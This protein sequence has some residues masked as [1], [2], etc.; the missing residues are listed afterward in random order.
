MVQLV[1]QINDP[2]DEKL[3]IRPCATASLFEYCELGTLKGLIEKRRDIGK[4]FTAYEVLMMAIQLAEGLCALKKAGLVHRDLAPRNIFVARNDKDE[5]VCKI[6]DIGLVVQL[7]PERVGVLSANVF[8]AH[9]LLSALDTV[10]QFL[11][12]FRASL[13][14]P[15]SYFGRDQCR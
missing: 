2:G 15:I 4:P 11:S 3:G 12:K 10:C 5:L 14:L 9:A 8:S 13:K 1:R 7:N 6:G